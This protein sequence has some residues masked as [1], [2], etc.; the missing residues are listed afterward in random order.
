[1]QLSVRTLSKQHMD[2]SW[3]LSHEK[4]VIEEIFWEAKAFW[5]SDAIAHFVE[6][7]KQTGNLTRTTIFSSSNCKSISTSVSR[8]LSSFVWLLRV[9]INQAVE[10]G[11]KRFL[12]GVL[13]SE[14]S[15]ATE[16]GNC[17]LWGHN[18]RMRAWS[19][20]EVSDRRCGQCLMVMKTTI[21]LQV[22]LCHQTWEKNGKIDVWMIRTE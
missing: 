2:L 18:G 3:K 12:K 19:D 13:F 1:M 4:R 22:T 8:K 21:L 10:L 5:W 7:M 15:N 20:H 11:K 6:K 14:D 17:F 16:S 9:H